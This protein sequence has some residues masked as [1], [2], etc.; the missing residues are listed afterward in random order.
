MP[1]EDIFKVDRKSE[2]MSETTVQ[3]KRREITDKMILFWKLQLAKLDRILD[4]FKE[5]DRKLIGPK[6]GRIFEGEV[7]GA[8]DSGKMSVNTQ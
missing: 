1:W 6:S 5:G 4:N 8:Q 3:Q 2:V 7:C